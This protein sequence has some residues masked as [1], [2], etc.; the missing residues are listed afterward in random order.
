MTIS[1]DHTPGV[2]SIAGA[3][4]ID[5]AHSLRDALLECLSH[6][7]E[8]ALDLSGVNACDAAALQVLLAAQRNAA[9]LGKAFRIA[10]DSRPVT[11]AAS[12]LGLSLEAYRDAA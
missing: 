3:L 5:A 11:E 2:L 8:V 1:K 7:P 4:D 10:G 9:A 6:Q 12:A